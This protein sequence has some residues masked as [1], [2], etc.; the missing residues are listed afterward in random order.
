MTSNRARLAFGI[1]MLL[2]A[3]FAPVLSQTKFMTHAPMRPLPTVSKRPLEKGTTYFVDV[4][5]GDDKQDGSQAKPFKTVQHAVKHLKPGETLYLRGGTYYE[6]VRL[7]RSGADDAP[8][9]IDW[10]G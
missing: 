7:T 8:I 9:T 2:V 1:V 3:D 4:A 10:V 5:K 6:R